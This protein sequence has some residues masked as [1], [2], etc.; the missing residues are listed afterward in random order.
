MYVGTYIR[1]PSIQM[2]QC[3]NVHVHIQKY[4]K[5]FNNYWNQFGTWKW[6]QSQYPYKLICR[7]SQK[8]LIAIPNNYIKKDILAQHQSLTIYTHFNKTS[9]DWLINPLQVSIARS[10]STNTKNQ[11]KCEIIC[12]GFGFNLPI[13]KTIQLQTP[14]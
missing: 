10:K 2:P 3:F 7:S 12:Y 6:N 9:P 14:L 13:M 4:L 8:I 5:Y 1:G 11:K